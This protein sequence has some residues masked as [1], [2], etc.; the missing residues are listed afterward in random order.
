MLSIQTG[1]VCARHLY[2]VTKMGT[3]FCLGPSQRIVIQILCIVYRFVQCFAMHWC[4]VLALVVTLMPVHAI[5]A[6]LDQQIINMTSLTDRNA[7]C[8]IWQKHK[9][10][11]NG[12]S[13]NSNETRQINITV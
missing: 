11:Y 8:P 1:V 13:T 7:S 4:I 6:K 12:K 9:Q 2:C 5:L 3:L 10:D